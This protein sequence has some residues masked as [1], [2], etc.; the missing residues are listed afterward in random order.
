MSKRKLK[1]A[2]QSIPSVLSNKKSKLSDDPY[3]PV[4]QTNKQRTMVFSNRGVSVTQKSLMNDVRT[5]LPHSKRES[6]YDTR[7]HIKE[8]N[9][10]CEMAGCNNCVYFEK[11]ESKYFLWVARVPY[12]PSAKFLINDVHSMNDLK[13]TGNC[14]KGSRPF[15]LFDSAFDGEPHMR[16][17]KELFIQAFGT[18]LGHLKSKPCFDHVISFFY[19]EGK[20]WF[21]NYQIVEIDMGKK[22]EVSLSEIGPRFCLEPVAIFEASFGGQVIYE[23]PD[24][25]SP[26]LERLEKRA[27]KAIK[28]ATKIQ[29]SQR[30]WRRK[31]LSVLTPG[32]LDYEKVFD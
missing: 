2:G 4:I 1:E 16:L 11:Q 8:I 26:A 24:F 22:K 19:L 9:E 18:P 29:A 23:N 32:E 14:L 30:R 21:R 28:Q 5:L 27:Q 17:T 7:R 13:L 6:K 20:I 10:L 12:G 15:L 31:Q 25:I 3:A